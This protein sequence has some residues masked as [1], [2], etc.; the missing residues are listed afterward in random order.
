MKDVTNI[1]KMNEANL[2]PKDIA[3]T[4]NTFMMQMEKQE[5]MSGR[6]RKLV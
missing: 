2:D 6:V 4:M 1:L 3:K 5:M